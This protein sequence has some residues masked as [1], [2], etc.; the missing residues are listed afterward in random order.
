MCI[1]DLDVKANVPASGHLANKFIRYRLLPLSPPH[2][3]NSTP[4]F[5]NTGTPI[6]GAIV[7]WVMQS[8]LHDSTL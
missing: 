8:V 2:S 1:S 4:S 5:G 3:Q 7:R 6:S